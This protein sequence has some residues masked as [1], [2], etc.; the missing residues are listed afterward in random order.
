MHKSIVSSEPHKS[1]N[2]IESRMKKGN[3]VQK[4]GR[5]YYFSRWLRTALV[6][7]R[8]TQ[9]KLPNTHWIAV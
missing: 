1:G 3:I 8:D 2:V 5:D 4:K 6:D 9:S 7:L